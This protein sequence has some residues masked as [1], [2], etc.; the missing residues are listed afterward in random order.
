MKVE[1]KCAVVVLDQ[2]G[3][4]DVVT[5]ESRYAAEIWCRGFKARDSLSRKWDVETII[6]PI[7]HTKYADHPMLFTFMDLGH[8]LEDGDYCEA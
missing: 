4:W 3:D 6:L 2:D 8:G 7:D 1:L 5:L